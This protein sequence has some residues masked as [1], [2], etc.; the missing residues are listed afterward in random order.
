[1]RSGYVSRVQLIFVGRVTFKED[2]EEAEEEEEEEEEGEGQGESIVTTSFV[3]WKDIPRFLIFRNDSVKKIVKCLSS[4][5]IPRKWF[6]LLNLSLS[7][8]L[9]SSSI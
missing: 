4:S 5:S 2:G 6:H 7:T 9:L 1:M 8:S 3:Q